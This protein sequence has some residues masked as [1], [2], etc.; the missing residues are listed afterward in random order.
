MVDGSNFASIDG[1]LEEPVKRRGGGHYQGRFALRDLL[2][3][4]N[5]DDVHATTSLSTRELADAVASNLVYTDQRVQRG[6]KPGKE[7]VAEVEL[8]LADGY[9]DTDTYIFYPDKADEIASKLLDGERLHLSPLIWN[10]RP[11]EF[12]AFIDP[13]ARKLFVYRGRIYLPDGHHRHQG[14]VKAQR[15]WEEAPDEYPSFDPDRQFTVDVH[16]MSREEEAQFFFEKNVLGKDVDKSKSYDLT[17]RD[18]LS[19]LA[20]AVIQ[21]SPSLSGNVNRVTDRLSGR[22]PQVVTLSTLHSMM[23]QIVGSDTALS[24]AR[25]EDLSTWLAAFYELLVEVRPELGKLELD[26]R[27][28]A[29]ATSMAGQA[30]VMHGFATLMGRFVEQVERE[31][32]ET[33]VAEW[34]P[35]LEDLSPDKRY[36]TEDDSFEG[37]LFDRENPVWREIGVLQK[38]RTGKDTVSNVRQ[39][40]ANAGHLLVE[41]VGLDE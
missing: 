19:N 2:L 30:V 1:L 21:K 17:A 23:E 22:N 27:Q 8:S 28:A 36:A 3:V 4:D 7:L 18:P 16:F 37:D 25:V 15:I 38:T 13:D 33:A 5:P 40:R 9:P 34:R 31:G 26:E 10:L 20:K 32:L 29:R 12:E 14:I 39:T 11:G 24:D 35:R 6:I 41:R